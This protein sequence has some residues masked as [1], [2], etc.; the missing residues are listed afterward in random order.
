M[1]WG[2]SGSKEKGEKWDY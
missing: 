2:R 1:S